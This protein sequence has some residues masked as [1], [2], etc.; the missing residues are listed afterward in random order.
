MQAGPHDDGVL[1]IN[2]LRVVVVEVDGA[3][4]EAEELDHPKNRF[5]Q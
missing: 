1:R 4:V 3:L 2:H 5:V